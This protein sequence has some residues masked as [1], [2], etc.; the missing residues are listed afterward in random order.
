[1]TRSF[2][3][4]GLVLTLHAAWARDYYVSPQGTDAAGCGTAASPC[5]RINFVFTQF[6][7]APTAADPAVVHVAPG[8]YRENAAP[9]AQQT[10]FAVPNFTHLISDKGADETFLEVDLGNLALAG[11][12]EVVRGQK[13]GIPDNAEGIILDGFTLRGPGGPVSMP[14]HQIVGVNFGS[15]VNTLVPPKNN[16]IRNNVISVQNTLGRT[17]SKQEGAGVFTSGGATI[18]CNVFQGIDSVG[19]AMSSVLSNDAGVNLTEPGTISRNWFRNFTNFYGA[20]GGGAPNP[21]GGEALYSDDE[22]I[23]I[24][25]NVPTTIRG[26]LLDAKREDYRDRKFGIA[27]F[28]CD[29]LVA[30]NNIL[31]NFDS[32]SGAAIGF[33]SIGKRAATPLKPRL[34]FNTVANTVDG[35]QHWLENEES[36]TNFAPEISNSILWVTD[37]FKDA[38]GGTV[39]V[40]I[41]YSNTQKGTMP[42]TGNLSAD[43]LF[44]NTVLGDYRLTDSSPSANAGADG[45]QQGAYGGPSPFG[46]PAN[47]QRPCRLRETPLEFPSTCAELPEGSRC[48]IPS[49]SGDSAQW[50]TCAGS[51]CSAAMT[52]LQGCDDQDVCTADSCQPGI[53]CAHTPIEGCASPNTDGGPGGK[54]PY[55]VGTCGCGALDFGF[56]WASLLGLIAFALRRRRLGVSVH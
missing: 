17:Q 53:G 12:V 18:D 41:D 33:V 51:A 37:T 27:C 56:T 43:P 42:G 46:E 13:F 19:I 4:L 48:G 25:V 40:K 26:N 44:R 30:E 22:Y 50:S 24:G 11:I 31:A 39:S 54:A 1:M 35:L 15:G 8:T 3:A 5:K 14:D 21:D 7:P 6:Q 20:D 10:G 52:S 34:A 28:D 49:C 29:Q 2:T 32:E 9:A 16:T 47:P 45:M 38:D 23:A 36:E 55:V